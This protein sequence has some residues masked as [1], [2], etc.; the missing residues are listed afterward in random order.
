MF[1][2]FFNK[3]K[4]ND[5]YGWNPPT[6]IYEID[7]GYIIEMEVPGLSQEDIK[8]SLNDGTITVSGEFSKTSDKE[9]KYLLTE[10]TVGSFTRTFNLP[11]G[12]LDSAS[13]SAKFNNGI[14]KVNIPKA[15]AAIPKEIK[16]T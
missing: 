9:S 10:R 4:V 8:I 6:N 13:T 2:Q 3:R 5:S 12:R 14:L 16:I 1:D 7:S 11:T 15:E